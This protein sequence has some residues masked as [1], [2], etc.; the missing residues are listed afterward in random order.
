MEYV[1]TIRKNLA[2]IYENASADIVKTISESLEDRGYEQTRK[3]VENAKKDIENRL[4]RGLMNTG[5]VAEALGRYAALVKWIE[6]DDRENEENE[7]FY[8]YYCQEHPDEV[9]AEDYAKY[10]NWVITP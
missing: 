9:P 6:D 5:E 7:K 3:A 8:A 4:N 2:L 1:K 10:A